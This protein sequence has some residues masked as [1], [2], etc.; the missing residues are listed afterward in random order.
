MNAHIERLAR[1]AGLIHGTFVKAPSREDLD[2]FAKA[3]AEDCALT[4]STLKENDGRAQARYVT[5][6]FCA[7]AIRERYK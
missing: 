6:K 2:A 4:V 7:D 1:E 5:A 3:I